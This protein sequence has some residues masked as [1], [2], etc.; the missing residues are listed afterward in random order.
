[1]PLPRPDR[2]GWIAAGGDERRFDLMDELGS[3]AGF[4]TDGARCVAA[5]HPDRPDLG[6]VADWTGTGEAA[7][8]VL[9][10][11]EEWL[12][13]SCSEVRGPMW[14]SPWFDHAA[15]LGPEET[16]PLWFE[17]RE[18]DRGWADAGYDI[19]T[20]YASILAAHEE[21]IRAGMNAAAKLSSRG[22]SLQPLDLKDPA[23]VEIVHGVLHRAHRDM[24]GYTHVPLE[25]WA[26]WYAPTI[27]SLEEPV[28]SRVAIHPDGQP[29]AYA[30]AFPEPPSAFSIPSIAVVPE[31]RKAGLASWLVATVHQAARKAGIDSGIHAMVRYGVGTREDTTWYRGD[32]VRRYALYSKRIR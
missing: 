15:N 13:E 30:L 32:V 21:N 14:M 5:V 20:S 26:A 23:A 11:A 8:A 4:A 25:I 18:T 12:G 7:A 24:P 3:V 22:W 10:A 2:A 9:Q 16:P 19:H 29:V 6:T 28:L 17:P 27:A 1:M 31:Q